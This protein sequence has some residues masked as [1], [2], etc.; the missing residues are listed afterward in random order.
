MNIQVLSGYGVSKVVASG[1]PDFKV[2]DHVWGRTGWEEY[3]L[4]P[5]PGSLFKIN[6]PEMPLSYYTGA[7]GGFYSERLLLVLL[8]LLQSKIVMF[9]PLTFLF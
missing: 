6:H 9:N 5:N 1:H 4:V 2:G 8:A 3:T 7:L